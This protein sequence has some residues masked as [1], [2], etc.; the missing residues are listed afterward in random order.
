MAKCSGNVTSE[1]DETLLCAKPVITMMEG[2]PRT[3]LD[4]YIKSVSRSRPD[5]YNNSKPDYQKLL[6]RI[7]KLG[8]PNMEVDDKIRMLA[9]LMEIP[10]S[11][12]TEQDV[13]RMLAAETGD[14]VNVLV[15]VVK[16]YTETSAE[17]KETLLAMTLEF[18]N[19][20]LGMYFTFLIC[21]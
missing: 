8:S 3:L 10:T 12:I 5:C 13:I 19:K 1:D 18:F 7:H 20:V 4:D 2:K 17:N 16:I 21:H 15:S 6:A 14:L 11:S 9:R